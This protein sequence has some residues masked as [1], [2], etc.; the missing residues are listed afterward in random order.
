MRVYNWCFFDSNTAITK[1]R[2][3]YTYMSQ[4][5]FLSPFAHIIY[6]NPLY[7]H[8]CKS[9]PLFWLPWKIRDWKLL[10]EQRWCQNCISVV[11]RVTILPPADKRLETLA[12]QGL[13]ISKCP[14]QQKRNRKQGVEKV[15]PDLGTPREI[16]RPNQ[17]QRLNSL[18][19]KHFAPLLF[20]PAFAL[21]GHPKSDT[22]STE[23]WEDSRSSLLRYIIFLQ[24][25]G[26]P[27]RKPW[28]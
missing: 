10:Y 1:F 8:F 22:I 9:T 5:H 12:A 3:P 23:E 4:R 2:V 7:S 21:T 17:F 25:G 14:R 20:L 11:L 16:I 27:I 18:R 19:H 6:Q 24:R 26:H 15:D 28:G 13:K